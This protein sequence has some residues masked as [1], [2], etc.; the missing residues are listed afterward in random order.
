MNV[1]AMIGFESHC[2]GRVV[3]CITSFVSQNR[4][5]PA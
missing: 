1:L 2:P 3:G 5:Y 4:I